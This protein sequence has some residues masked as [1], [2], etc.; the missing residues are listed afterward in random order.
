M[1]A[2]A[3]ACPACH[4]PLPDEAQ[5]CLHCGAATPTEP[6]V[7]PRVA[8]T[9]AVEVTK[10]TKALAGLY[11][12]ERVLGEGGM[13]TVYLAEDL[14]HRRKVAVKVMR[15]ELTATLGADR[16][17][18]EIEI[19]AQLTHPH[20][21]PVHDSGETGGVLYYVMPYVEGESLRER[22]QREGQLSIDEAVR[23]AREVAEALGYAHGRGII[24]RDIKPANILLGQ[25]HALVADFG[26]ARATEGGAA[27]TQTGLAVG[28]PQYMSPEQAAGERDVDA[29]ADVYAIGAVLYEML[30]GQP[31]Y[32]GATPQAILAKTLTEEVRPLTSVRS[33]VPKAV[34]TVVAKA[35]ARHPAERY[36]SASELERALAGALDSARSGATARAAQGPSA[37]QVWGLFGATAAVTL[38]VVAGLVTRWGLA[39]WT[40]GL[41]GALLAVGAAVLVAT[42]RIEARRRAG[43]A[44]AGFARWFSWRNAA[45]GG[46]LAGALW[47]IVALGVVF[48]GPGASAAAGGGGVRLAVLPFDNRGDPAD[49]YFVDGVADQVRGKLTGLGGFQI[50]ARTSSD[51]YRKST[52]SP[53]DIGRELGV[54]YL[55]TA[56]V[57]WAKTPGSSGR[58]Q[59]IPE[60]ID[61]RT[62]TAT[63]QQT[64]DAALTDVFQVQADIAVR[65]AGALNVALGVGEQQEITARPTENLAAYDAFLRGEE[66]RRLGG[67][68][69]VRD[70]ANAYEQAVALDSSFALAWARLAQ[71]HAAANFMNPTPEDADGARRAAERARQLA[72]DAPETHVALG[73]YYQNVLFDLPRASDQ[74]AEGLRVAPNHPDLLV[75][76]ANVERSLGRWDHALELLQRAEKLDPRSTGATSMA[77]QVLLWQ[78]RYPETLAQLDK[79]LALAPASMSLVEAK[80]MVCL[81]EGDLPRAQAVLAAAPPEIEPTRLVAFVAGTWDLFW[82]LD[83]EQQGLLLRLSPGAFDNDRGAWALALAATHALR[84][85]AAKARAYGDS[86]QLVYA[87]A[88]HRAPDDNYLLALSGLALAFAGKRDEAIRNGERSVALL[89]VTKDAFSGAYNQHLLAR[90]YTVLGESDKAIDQL[91]TL[92]GVPYYLSA[93]WL[94]IDPTFAPLR[95]NPRF[96]RLIAGP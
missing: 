46:G 10:V 69:G 66:A 95:A 3:R 23:L 38:A 1:P 29:R 51:Q 84:G 70:A 11:R 25:G 72:P 57:A 30:A 50:T 54:D 41:A 2:S 79:A 19:A 65:V 48:K 83:D 49:E 26:I 17:L 73:T 9:G 86:A 43:G 15:P 56:T 13:A 68:S 28:T 12:V 78:R 6:G 53:Q 74:Y 18:R 77:A 31:P 88:L 59:V 96:A 63:W 81:A 36:A 24:H 42:G 80:A 58:V 32:T 62:G 89:P 39:R 64:F 94:K 60:L 34:G 47:V 14:K 90:T 44:P 5:F 91:Q 75:S 92:L 82:V 71:V 7:P 67:Q 35:M 37:V 16:F 4:T 87:E 61:A 20:V 45:F 21:L 8:A 22:V 93:A 76:T 85:N 52:K 40:L 55:L 33:N 27:L